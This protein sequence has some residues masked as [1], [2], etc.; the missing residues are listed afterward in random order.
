MFFCCVLLLSACKD[1]STPPATPAVQATAA[2]PVT[3]ID[4]VPEPAQP[5][6]PQ[7]IDSLPANREAR[8]AFLR[9]YGR[10]RG[11]N[12]VR[13]TTPQGVIEIRLFDETPTYKGSFLWLTDQGY[14]DTTYFHR[15]VPNFV[16]QGGNSDNAPTNKM[17]N[18][19]HAYQ[20]PPE[21]VPSLKHVAGMVSASKEWEGNPEHWHSPFEFFVV[22]GKHDYLN[23]EHTIFGKVTRGMNV[24][25]AI[26]QLET[27]KTG[28]PWINVTIDAEVVE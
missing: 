8:E 12:R 21:Y 3:P 28:W 1:T 11:S 22:M 24:V 20:L 18:A 6:Q 17:R 25:R 27:D 2:E 19:V 10:T 4:E 5:P 16:I 23:G 13:L 15:T 26:N 14:F 9:E 7:I